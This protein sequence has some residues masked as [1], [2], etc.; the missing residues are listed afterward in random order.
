M[1]AFSIVFAVLVMLAPAVMWAQGEVTLEGLADDIAGLTETVNA[2][3]SRIER[4]ESI[5]DGPG[6]AGLADDVCQLTERGTM[7]DETVLKYKEKFGKWL[8]LNFSMIHQVRHSADTGNVLIIYTDGPF[9][10]KMVIEEW[11]G[12]EFVGASDWWEE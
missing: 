2:L 12:C 4:I 10:S 8:D 5:W 1:K 11:N 3:V 9:A 6:S 7:Q